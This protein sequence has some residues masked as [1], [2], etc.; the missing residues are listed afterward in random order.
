MRLLPIPDSLHR[1]KA[2]P[3]DEAAPSEL[4]IPTYRASRGVEVD[5]GVEVGRKGD[6][7]LMQQTGTE[8]QPSQRAEVIP[9]PGRRRCQ[10]RLKHQDYQCRRKQ[11]LQIRHKR[12]I[13]IQ[14]L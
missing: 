10:S 9:K 5:R 1:L 11:L 6:V 4:D 2:D 8:I 14:L 7:D 3:K 12:R 13:S